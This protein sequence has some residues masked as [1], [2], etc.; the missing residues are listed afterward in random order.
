MTIRP[1]N[2]GEL[3]DAVRAHEAIAIRGGGTKSSA[4]NGADRV[5]LDLGALRGVTDY[6]PA[7]CVFTVLAGTRV[8]EI[9]ALLA[10][11]G[12]YLP[13]DPPLV[14]AGA[15][16]GG[17][18]A[19]G[20][21]GSGR[22]RYGGVRD[23]LIGARVVD[24]EGRVVRSGGRVVKNA[25][26]FLLHHGIVGSRG[27]FGVIAELTFKV[28]PAPRARATIRAACGS[29]EAAWRTALAIEQERLDLDALDF[30]HQ[31][32]LWARVAGRR[33]TLEARAA[34]LRQAVPG[35]ALVENDDEIWTDA[36]EWSWAPPDASMVKVPLARTAGLAAPGRYTA[37][38]RCLWTAVR[39]VDDLS[40][41]LA[42]EGLRGEVVRGARA[43]V[44]V[45]RV[46]HNTFE[47]RVRHVLDPQ[48]RFGAA[49][50]PGC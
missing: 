28:F 33:E 6:Q 13:F 15:T 20:V 22:Y 50:D 10:S 24:G 25:A 48:D 14:E 40:Q 30:D 41:T 9:T 43:G 46:E 37:A 19:A 32:V 45:G 18:V 4:T 16:I 31:G 36:R 17:T 42:Q 47:E 23:F 44:R 34:R 21:N 49:P 2:L 1:Q 12:Q 7:E 29:V 11:S 5:T 3:Q 8:S 26:G 38:G 27:R 39:D 35:A